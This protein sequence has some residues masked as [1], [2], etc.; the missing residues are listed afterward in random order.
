MVRH[1]RLECSPVQTRRD[2]QTHHELLLHQ[3]PC[4]TCRQAYMPDRHAV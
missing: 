4:R 3:C 2:K 1:N